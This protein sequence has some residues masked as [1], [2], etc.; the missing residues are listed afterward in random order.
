MITLRREKMDEKMPA[1]F[2]ICFLVLVSA[3]ISGIDV[4]S[5]LPLI[6][7][8]LLVFLIVQEIKA[9]RKT[10]DTDRWIIPLFLAV[11]LFLTVDFC[12]RGDIIIFPDV[13][14]IITFEIVGIVIL[15]QKAKFVCPEL[16]KEI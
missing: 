14:L 13:M 1:Y 10:G 15:F 2:I 5:A 6:I 16:S 7:A 8:V 3:G 4:M 9:I 12:L 11:L